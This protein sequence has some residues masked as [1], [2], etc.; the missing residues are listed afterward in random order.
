MRGIFRK[1]GLAA[2]VVLAAATAARADTAIEAYRA[3]GIKPASVLSGT[4][5]NARVVPGPGKQV[6]SVT[7]YFT[8]DRDPSTAV[9][10]RFD[11]FQRRGENLV[12]I[13]TRDLGA[14]NGGNVGRGDLQLVDLDSD[15][16]N[17]IILTFDIHSDPLIEQR[18]SEV[19]IH[20]GD[21]FAT[22]WTGPVEYD[23]T[24]AAREVPLERRD[25]Y[26]REIDF[27]ATLG[28]QGETLFFKKTV[29][30]VAGER[31]QQ[32]KLVHESFPLR[33]PSSD[34]NPDS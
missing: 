4:V 19:V 33:D 24:R 32:P 22:A 2:A 13:Y 14:E 18:V 16:I 20:G 10:V 31:L 11:V 34:A 27:G 9:S 5:L 21:G 15:G 7:T 30:A 12:Q 3:M 29:I 25:R 1:T 26:R 17:E 23:A 28:S 6:V 8:G